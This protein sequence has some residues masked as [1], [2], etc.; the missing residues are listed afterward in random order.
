MA[1]T[2]TFG[3]MKILLSSAKTLGPT[4]LTAIQPPVFLAEAQKHMA[5]IQQWN[6]QKISRFYGTSPALSA[7]VQS[8]HQTWN[9]PSQKPNTPCALGQFKG[10]AFAKLDVEHLPPT[11]Q[12]VAMERIVIGSGLYGLLRASDAM[13]PYRLDM[14]QKLDTRGL[15]H[16][17]KPRISDWLRETLDGG[18]CINLASAEYAE[19]I[20]TTGIDWVDVEFWQ[21][22][23]GKRKAVSVFSKQARGLMARHLCLHPELGVDALAHFDAE[24]Y[25]LDRDL[26]HPK[27]WVFVR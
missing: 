9:A 15:R 22:A 11:A 10:E 2:P 26:S 14:D 6:V 23:G 27:R 7:K 25:Q 19:A 4:A 17:W 24:D 5:E 21:E 20:D 8:M 13:Q 1:P 16:F 12:S 18:P 3:Q